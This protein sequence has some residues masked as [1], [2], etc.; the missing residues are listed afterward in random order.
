MDEVFSLPK[1]L[2]LNIEEIRRDNPEIEDFVTDLY[3]QLRPSLI[4]Y[5]YHLMGSTRDA[6]DVVQIAFIQL[7]DQLKADVEIK[8]IRAWLYKVAHNLAIGEARRSGRREAL[9]RQ[10][11][12]GYEPDSS[13]VEEDLLR[14]EQIEVT[15]GILNEKEQRCLMLRAEGLTYQEIADVVDTTA[16]SVSVY[17]ARGLKKFRSRH[18][19]K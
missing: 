6:E 16:K 7:F 10:W 9:F 12:A 14:R 13:S 1:A 3:T 19:D 18:E 8:N 15:L 17:L 2:S 4:S 5:V 11:L